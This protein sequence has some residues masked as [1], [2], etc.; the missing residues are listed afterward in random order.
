MPRPETMSQCQRDQGRRSRR[1]GMQV[2]MVS[3]LKL[4]F[5]PFWTVLMGMC[6]AGLGPAVD[7]NGG[8]VSLSERRI[9][10]MASSFC[11]VEFSRLRLAML[12]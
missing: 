3:L 9:G 5:E 11:R 12:G 10:A 1:A 2:R 8:L 6:D 4:L 7:G